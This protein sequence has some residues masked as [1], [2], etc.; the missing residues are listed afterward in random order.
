MVL[1]TKKIIE[2][3]L[4]KLI[5]VFRSGIWIVIS[6]TLLGVLIGYIY[7]NYYGY[8]ENEIQYKINI[9]IYELRHTDALKLNELN[10]NIKKL[11]LLQYEKSLLNYQNSFTPDVLSEFENIS[12]IR[13]R[14][15][16]EEQTLTELPQVI[17]INSKCLDIRFEDDNVNTQCTN[18]FFN[19]S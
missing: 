8:Y 7:E 12:R 19:V 13:I 14:R 9:P 2:L 4:S 11:Y 16:I 6:F 17:E 1:N 5:D 15:F 10:F 18:K 3:D